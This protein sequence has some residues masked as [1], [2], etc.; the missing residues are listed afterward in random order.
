[1]LGWLIDPNERLIFTYTKNSQPL[2][3]E[4]KNEAIPVPDFAQDVQITLGDIFGWLQV[5]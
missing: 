5:N 1:M 2:F 4:D 3:F